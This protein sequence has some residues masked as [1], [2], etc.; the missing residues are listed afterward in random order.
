M[1]ALARCS[2]TKIKPFKNVLTHAVITD[3]PFLFQ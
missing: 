1:V 3:K 2:L